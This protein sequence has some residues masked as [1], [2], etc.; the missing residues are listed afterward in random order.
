MDIMVGSGVNHCKLDNRTSLNLGRLHLS[1]PIGEKVIRYAYIRKN[2]CS[3]FKS[4]LGYPPETEI[5]EI[6]RKHGCRWKRYDATIFVWRDPEERLVSLYRNKIIDGVNNEEIMRK[7]ERYCEGDIY[8]FEKFVEFSI[9]DLD[10]HCLPQSSH[11]RPIV[12]THAIPLKRL[13]Q[14]MVEI[15][16]REAAQ[17]FARS[18]NASRPT[19]VDVTEKARRMI[20]Q[21]YSRD[22]KLIARLADKQV[23]GNTLGV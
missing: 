14:A 10:P 20:R 22:Y 17:P 5:S 7:Y 2:G 8:D 18:V 6:K 21:H 16:G 19:P 13:Y 9:L 23:A 11:L 4:A 12:Y 3:A 1:V 15:V